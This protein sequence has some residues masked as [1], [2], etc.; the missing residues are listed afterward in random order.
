M[1]DS[2]G[3]GAGSPVPTRDAATVLLLRDGAAGLETWLMRRVPKMA[4]APSMSVFPG[5]G[6]DAVD[7]TGPDRPDVAERFGID[8]QLAGV[9]VRAAVREIEEETGVVLAAGELQPWARWIT[10]E[11]ESRRYDTYFF[12]A[13]LPAGALAASIS[14]E[15]SVAEWVPVIEALA[16]YERG[17]RPMLPPTVHNLT[18]VAGFG[19]AVEVVAAAERRS[20]SAIMPTLRLDGQGNGVADLGNGELVPLPVNFVSATGRTPA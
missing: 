5:G 18:A 7:A 11:A 17:E 12:V 8:A 3:A 4:F 6:V 15:A 2:A 13:A 10:P 1:S 20:I 16:Q 19:S 14:S 9:I